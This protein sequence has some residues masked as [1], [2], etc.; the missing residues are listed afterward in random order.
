M[1][2]RIAT[3]T[4]FNELVHLLLPMR[5]PHQLQIVLRLL[6]P[7]EEPEDLVISFHN[8][9][10][11]YHVQRP[12]DFVPHRHMV[13]SF[14]R[15]ETLVVGFVHLSTCVCCLCRIRSAK[16]KLLQI[17]S[18]V[19]TLRCHLEGSVQILGTQRQVVSSR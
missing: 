11:K 15:D 17:L 3:E 16:R 13:Q 9:R 4:V 12:L 14:I 7:Q 10:G 18:N 6:D 2:K 8:S 19:Q 5:R 1:R